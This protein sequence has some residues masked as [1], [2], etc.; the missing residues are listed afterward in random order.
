MLINVLQVRR[1][2]TDPSLIELFQS[3]NAGQA[4]NVAP[5]VPPHLGFPA[6]V[7]AVAGASGQVS[8]WKSQGAPSGQKSVAKLKKDH[9]I[10][11]ENVYF[12]YFTINLNFG[13]I[14]LASWH[15]LLFIVLPLEIRGVQVDISFR[16]IKKVSIVNWWCC[17][18]LRF[19]GNPAESK[20]MKQVNQFVWGFGYNTFLHFVHLCTIFFTCSLYLLCFLHDTS[21]KWTWQVTNE[22]VYVA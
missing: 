16:V 20:E 1:P 15:N 18:N 5:G 9:L 11:Y 6:R 10:L 7:H 21:S 2:E 3:I 17:P 12:W 4:A 22:T 14:S 19:R 8:I 13:G